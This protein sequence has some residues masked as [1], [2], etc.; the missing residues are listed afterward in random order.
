M[1]SNCR[2]IIAYANGLMTLWDLHEKKV[3][4]V[5]GGTRKQQETLAEHAASLQEQ[6]FTE[7][8]VEQAA[9]FSELHFSPPKATILNEV[10][11]EEEKEICTVCWACVDTLVAGYVDGDVWLWTFPPVSKDK[12]ESKCHF[13]SGTPLR[14]LDLAHGK[15]TRMPVIVLR[16]SSSAK[17]CNNGGGRLYVFGGGEVG[18]PQA[19]TVSFVRFIRLLLCQ[20]PVWLQD[21][22]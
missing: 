14:K 10:D 9:G 3:L 22:C 5:R 20:L 19:V 13:S 1:S 17:T 7:K 21:L 16:W 6:T 2:L 8:L 4:A 18:L 12:I 11:E 15:S